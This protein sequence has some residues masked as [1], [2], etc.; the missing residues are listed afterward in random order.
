MRVWLSFLTLPCGESGFGVSGLL[1]G[2]PLVTTGGSTN[3]RSSR[4][5]QFLIDVQGVSGHAT[6]PQ[7]LYI[8]ADGLLSRAPIALISQECLDLA[9]Q[10]LAAPAG[11]E[12]TGAPHIQHLGDPVDVAGENCTTRLAPFGDYE[13]ERF[14]SERQHE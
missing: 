10:D 11:E 14:S 8:L 1:A 9:G 4:V 7:P 2:V 3:A 6:R 5:D 13:S 12:T